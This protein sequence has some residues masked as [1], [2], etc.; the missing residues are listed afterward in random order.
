MTTTTPDD[1]VTT[2]LAALQQVPEDDRAPDQ[3]DP[4]CATTGVGGRTPQLTNEGR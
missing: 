4:T 3:L 2:D 1:D